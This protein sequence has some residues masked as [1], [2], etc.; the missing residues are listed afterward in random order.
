MHTLQCQ[1]EGGGFLRAG[2]RQ[3]KVYIPTN[4]GKFLSNLYKSSLEAEKRWFLPEFGEK[5]SLHLEIGMIILYSLKVAPFGDFCGK[6]HYFPVE[7]DKLLHFSIL[8]KGDG[9]V[10]A[11]LVQNKQGSRRNRWPDADPADT[12]PRQTIKIHSGGI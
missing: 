2:N 9:S 4:T 1:T 5:S 10:R 8:T 12:C 3:N 6:T 7:K 11:L